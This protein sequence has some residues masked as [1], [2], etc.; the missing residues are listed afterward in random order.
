MFVLGQPELQANNAAS[1]NRPQ[2]PVEN[3]FIK[4]HVE[5]FHLYGDM[6][7]SHQLKNVL[8]NNNVFNNLVLE[9]ETNQLC[10][11]ITQRKTEINRLDREVHV[12]HFY[13]RLIFTIKVYIS[14]KI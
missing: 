11:L 6:G 5:K 10:T 2:A 13:N 4:G 3:Q 8:K 9:S 7:V 1:A 12:W 14:N